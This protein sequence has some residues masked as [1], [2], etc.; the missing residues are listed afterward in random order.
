[1]GREGIA[2]GSNVVPLLPRC[3]T[4]G[5]GLVGSV[6]C[7][8]EAVTQTRVDLCEAVRPKVVELWLNPHE[9]VIR[10]RGPV[11]VQ[12]VPKLAAREGQKLVESAGLSS[13]Q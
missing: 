9:C 13:D 2:S 3:V 8:Q 12:G 5:L 7:V 10:T 6:G 4:G 11:A 1:M